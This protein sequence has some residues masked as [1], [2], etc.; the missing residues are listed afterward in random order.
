MTTRI[1]YARLATYC[2]LTTYA[3]PSVKMRS[4]RKGISRPPILGSLAMPLWVDDGTL[5]PDSGHRQRN[6]RRL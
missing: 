6:F 1:N 2:R 3:P 5:S 4:A